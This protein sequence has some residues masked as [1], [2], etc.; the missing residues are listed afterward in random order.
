[1][2]GSTLF[3]FKYYPSMLKFDE[4]TRSDEEALHSNLK[5]LHGPKETKSEKTVDIT[6]L[7]SR[8]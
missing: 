8:K 5:Y 2:S 3:S 7:L 4:V 1:M 6:E